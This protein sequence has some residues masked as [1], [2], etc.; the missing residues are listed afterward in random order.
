VLFKTENVVTK[1]RGRGKREEGKRR[2]VGTFIHET[3]MIVR[4]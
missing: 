1:I 4:G 2:R 3:N